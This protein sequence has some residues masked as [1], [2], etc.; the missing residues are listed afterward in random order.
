MWENI[1][2]FFKFYTGYP[3]FYDS[4]YCDIPFNAIAIAFYYIG[5]IIIMVKES[6]GL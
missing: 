5:Q 6:N 1:A 2:F 3:E 4:R